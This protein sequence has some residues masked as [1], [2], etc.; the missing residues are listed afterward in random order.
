MLC[1]LFCTE[2]A[3]PA[4]QPQRGGGWPLRSRGAEAPETSRAPCEGKHPSP[5]SVGLVALQEGRTGKCL[6][7]AQCLGR[8]PVHHVPTP[9]P[10]P[11]RSP[12]QHLVPAGYQGSSGAS[13]RQGPILMELRD[14]HRGQLENHPLTVNSHKCQGQ[15]RV[16]QRGQPMCQ[17]LEAQCP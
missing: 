1:W 7:C 15:C 3:C 4:G 17:K 5:L 16:A 11:A 9:Q 6:L 10:S 8:G 13:G 14:G 12:G 2:T